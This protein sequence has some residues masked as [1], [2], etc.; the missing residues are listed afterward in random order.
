VV[1]ID[2]P[3]ITDLRSNSKA[4]DILRRDITRVCEYFA[5]QGV[6]ND[7]SAIMDEL[8]ERYADMTIDGYVDPP[9]DEGEL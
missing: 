3:Q 5:R 7:P 9:I 1:I 8:W 4:D 6:P 2:F